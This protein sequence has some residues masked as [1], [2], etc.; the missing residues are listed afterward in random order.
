MILCVSR[1]ILS[2]GQDPLLIL[3][4]MVTL[5]DQVT[6]CITVISISLLFLNASILILT[7]HL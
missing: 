7:Q 3:E 5:R 4:L 6:V 1:E 2:T